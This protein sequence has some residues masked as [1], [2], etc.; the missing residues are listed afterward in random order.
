MLGQAA[1]QAMELSEVTVVEGPV[2]SLLTEG[3]DLATLLGGGSRGS[4]PMGP[5]HGSLLRGW[6][7][8]AVLTLWRQEG[9]SHM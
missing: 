7:C 3:Q 8:P 4:Y 5:P 2:T 9:L 1:V 6:S